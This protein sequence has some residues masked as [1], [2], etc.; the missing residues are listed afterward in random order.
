MVRDDNIGGPVVGI[1]ERVSCMDTLRPNSRRERALVARDLGILVTSGS[2]IETRGNNSGIV[3][4]RSRRSTSTGEQDARVGIGPM[5]EPTVVGVGRVI[6]GGHIG[7]RAQPGTVVRRCRRADASSR[8]GCGHLS[9]SELGAGDASRVV[10]VAQAV[11]EPEIGPTDTDGAVQMVDTNEAFVVVVEAGAATEVQV[12]LRAGC[13]EV[14]SVDHVRSHGSEQSRRPDVED[15]RVG[16][17]GAG[18][19]S[20][21]AGRCCVSKAFLV[22]HVP[23]CHG[24]RSRRCL[25]GLVA[26]IHTVLERKDVG[27]PGGGIW[28]AGTGAHIT[29]NLVYHTWIARQRDLLIVVSTRIYRERCLTGCN[30]VGTGAQ[31]TSG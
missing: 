6:R 7:E 4:G 14:S 30:D 9:R 3:V 29:F 2:A 20:T 12:V 1:G 17:Q 26:Q 24:T 31:G 25:V 18:R 22:S 28:I 13:K 16:C 8:L 10:R 27:I 15:Q 19:R 11:D 21:A 23:V 5:P